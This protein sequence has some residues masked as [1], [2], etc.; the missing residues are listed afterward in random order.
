M[1]APLLI[2]LA[3]PHLAFAQTRSEKH[4]TP[5]LSSVL[6]TQSATVAGWESRRQLLRREWLEILGPMPARGDLHSTV[7]TTEPQVGYIRHLIRYETEAGSPVFAHLLIPDPLPHPAPAAVVFHATSPNHI[8]QPV[9]LADAPTRHIALYMVRRGYVVI[10]PENYIY[11]YQHDTLSTAP[12]SIPEFTVAARKLQSNHPKWTG[13]GKMLWDGMRAVDYLLTRSEVD[14][15]RIVC[16]GHSLGAKN[17]LYLTAFDTRVRAGIASEGGVGLSLSNWDA[18]WYFGTRAPKLGSPHDHHELLAM[19]APRAIMIAG[20]SSAD[21]PQSQPWI[22]AA[23]PI[24][25]LY[26]VADH[27][28]LVLHTKGHDFPDD[29]REQSFQWLDKILSESAPT[30]AGH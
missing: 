11:G 16:A 30:S 27:L 12:R 23:M 8:F 17:A 14:P 22:D 25:K 26:G 24:F 15:T 21:G 10:C 6:S 18:P 3:T 4:M 7:L 20:G 28:Q 29:I 19:V 2:F 9:G 13:M 1:L 5:A